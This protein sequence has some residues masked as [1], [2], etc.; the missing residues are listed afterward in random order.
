[1]PN[2]RSKSIFML[3]K[4]WNMCYEKKIG[5]FWINI[6]WSMLYHQK[7]YGLA[8]ILARMKMWYQLRNT[9]RNRQFSHKETH[10][11]YPFPPVQCWKENWIIARVTNFRHDCMNSNCSHLV[12]CRYA[13]KQ[14]CCRYLSTLNWGEGVRKC[15]ILHLHATLF[16]V[17]VCHNMASSLC[18]P[19]IIGTPLRQKLNM[20]THFMLI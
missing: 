18:V 14:P 2:F 12:R 7:P 5:E 13:L 20:L 15:S 9:S 6:N 4:W 19:I 3:K 16:V 17:I 10:F 11:F 1:M 8:I